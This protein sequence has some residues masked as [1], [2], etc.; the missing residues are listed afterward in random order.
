MLDCLVFQIRIG[1]LEADT[2][3]GPRELAGEHLGQDPRHYRH[4]LHG[5]KKGRKVEICFKHRRGRTTDIQVI[6]AIISQGLHLID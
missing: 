1:D 2:L 4:D 5:R 6:S 3:C